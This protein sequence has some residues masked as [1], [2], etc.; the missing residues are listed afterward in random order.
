MLK[1]K[2]AEN[3]DGAKEITVTNEAKMHWKAKL[4]SSNASTNS[5]NAN[6]SKKDFKEVWSM[7]KDD[8]LK[9]LENPWK[10]LWMPEYDVPSPDLFEWY[11]A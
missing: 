3:Q 2:E 10:S 4:I 9:R 1:L 5:S 6:L 7:V 8:V 11:R